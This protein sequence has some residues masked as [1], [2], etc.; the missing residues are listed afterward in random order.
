VNRSWR[1]AWMNSSMDEK[2]G[3]TGIYGRFCIISGMVV[4]WTILFCIISGM[5]VPWTISK[6]I[7]ETIISFSSLIISL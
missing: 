5:V 7:L 6:I 3:G 2:F 4:P 1:Q